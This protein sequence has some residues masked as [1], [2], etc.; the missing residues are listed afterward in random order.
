MVQVTAVAQIQSLALEVSY[1]AGAAIKIRKTKQNKKLQMKL[2]GRQKWG[3][4]LEK[5]DEGLITSI[6]KVSKNQKKKS[7]RFLKMQIFN[8]K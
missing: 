5:Y 8:N 3:E 7:Q 4:Y 2:K 6:V 1:A